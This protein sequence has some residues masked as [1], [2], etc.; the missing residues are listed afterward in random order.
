V[1]V[2]EPAA[3]A[4]SR[5]CALHPVPQPENRS[6]GG[7][8]GGGGGCCCEGSDGAGQQEEGAVFKKKKNTRTQLIRQ[9]QR[10]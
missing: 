6:G 4:H 3:H 5:L 1:E 8:G 7:G 10:A 2:E 9:E